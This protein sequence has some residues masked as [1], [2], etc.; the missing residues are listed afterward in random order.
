M[1]IKYIHER[2]IYIVDLDPSKGIEM[3]KIRPCLVL[4]KFN[5]EHFIII[6]LSS[7][8]KPQEISYYI[9][10]ISFL[11]KDK[12]WFVIS[13]SRVVD[14]SRFKR[15]LGELSYF[16]FSHI[17]KKSAEVLKLLPQRGNPHNESEEKSSSEGYCP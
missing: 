13:Q 2:E 7:M 17:Q 16:L 15:K 12:N 3:R 14:K 6:P 10:K 11:S 4:R 9:E 8:P 1:K 5:N